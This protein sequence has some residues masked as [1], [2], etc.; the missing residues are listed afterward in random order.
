MRCRDGTG[1]CC[2]NMLHLETKLGC[3]RLLGF[4]GCL[5]GAAV[6]FFVSFLTLP[7]LALRPAKFA[8]SFRSVR[9]HFSL[10]LP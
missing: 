5:L 9:L 10:L 8:L 1:E 6:C 2:E 7:M 3:P 4:G